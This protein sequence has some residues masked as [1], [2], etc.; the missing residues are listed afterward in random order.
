MATA[1]Q[2]YSS[3]EIG[4]ESDRIKTGGGED[5]FSHFDGDELVTPPPGPTIYTAA[6]ITTLGVSLK[7]NVLLSLLVV[8]P[9]W[10]MIFFNAVASLVIIEFIHQLRDETPICEAN[11]AL[12]ILGVVIFNVY[13][14][15]EVYETIDMAIWIS[16]VI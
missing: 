5:V 6:V 10:L 8:L 16:Q 12:L 1:K 14:V 13:N 7:D 11:K 2:A 15:G 9:S 3:L 4:S